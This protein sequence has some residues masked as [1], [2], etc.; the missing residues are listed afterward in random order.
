M[1]ANKTDAAFLHVA[2]ETV[3]SV[4]DVP[5][6]PPPSPPAAAGMA[7]S[8]LGGVADQAAA[9]QNGHKTGAELVAMWHG[10]GPGKKCWCY[11]VGAGAALQRVRAP[12]TPRF[13]VRA[14][15][16]LRLCHGA[17]GYG[18]QSLAKKLWLVP[19]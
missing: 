16:H 11:P 9:V 6:R 19:S 1:L 15:S 5:L 4:T 17:N 12:A 10:L 13:T 7:V 2:T 3:T 14:A 8:F 18:T